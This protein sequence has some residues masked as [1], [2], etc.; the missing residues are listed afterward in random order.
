MF[1][2]PQKHLPSP[3]HEQVSG[4][5]HGLHVP[6]VLRTIDVH[7][8]V[9]KGLLRQ[10]KAHI[11]GDAFQSYLHRQFPGVE[12]VVVKGKKSGEVEVKNS[13]EGITLTLSSD[14]G[15]WKRFAQKV[16]AAEE[17][18]NR[19]VALAS[20][21]LLALSGEKSSQSIGQLVVE[22]FVNDLTLW[23]QNDFKG[24]PCG[25]LYHLIPS[26]VRENNGSK[27]SW[28]ERIS[29]I[30]R[31]SSHPGISDELRSMQQR[32]EKE[33]GSVSRRIQPIEGT[34]DKEAIL[35]HGKYL[36]QI[37]MVSLARYFSEKN[38]DYLRFFSKEIV[39]VF[40]PTSAT[41][42]K[43]IS[44]ALREGDDSP[45]HELLEVARVNF[46]A[47]KRSGVFA[48]LQVLEVELQS[49]IQ[50]RDKY[51]S[52]SLREQ[53]TLK[54]FIRSNSIL[55]NEC[56]SLPSNVVPIKH[57]LP[58]LEELLPSLDV[59][60]A[61]D[62]RPYREQTFRLGKELI[63]MARSSDP[64]IVEWY[65][66]VTSGRRHEADYLDQQSQQFDE[67]FPL[68]V[69]ELL[70]EMY[71]WGASSAATP[72]FPQ[73]QG[74]DNLY[75]QLIRSVMYNGALTLFDEITEKERV[76]PIEILESHYHNFEK[77]VGML[78]ALEIEDIQSTFLSLAKYFGKY[79]VLSRKADDAS[80]N[81]AHKEERA[82]RE[83]AVEV[84][85][86]CGKYFLGLSV[87]FQNELKEEA[88][89]FLS[90]LPPSLV[91]LDSCGELGRQLTAIETAVAVLE[92]IGDTSHLTSDFRARLLRISNELIEACRYARTVSLQDH[93]GLSE[94]NDI[95]S[96]VERELQK[97]EP[98]GAFPGSR[99]HCM[100]ELRKSKL[101]VEKKRQMNRKERI[102]ASR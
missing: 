65:R 79:E 18:E 35:E 39:R 81:G 47:W 48:V 74:G 88:V 93:S 90:Q 78:K 41:F 1:D 32:L 6:G 5:Q 30:G 14:G 102:P 27:P 12:K 4:A 70:H 71:S 7:D 23:G 85:I 13:A 43:S 75:R 101:E 22:Q 59:P 49:P 64:K 68:Y 46:E 96:F 62:L 80:N 53:S 56:A 66:Y 95:L 69:L 82:L 29:E 40:E 42:E 98:L 58:I 55:K 20:E 89:T 100:D 97:W 91:L 50:L 87:E 61:G 63:A 21:S 11:T 44:R 37:G 10:V 84:M 26:L 2:Q 25:S 24:E 36:G 19:M 77:L 15:A 92:V 52:W 83:S 31:I 3:L 73:I 57:L 76:L 9:P 67:D 16:K 38:E 17:K 54:D 60:T 51:E 94:V 28:I 72:T 99:S 45:L 34:F 33:I 8:S 86:G